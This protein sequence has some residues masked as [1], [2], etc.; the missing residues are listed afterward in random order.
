[1]NYTVKCETCNYVFVRRKKYKKCF[2][3]LEGVR[4]LCGKN[5]ETPE[6]KAKIRQWCVIRLI[7]HLDK[8]ATDRDELT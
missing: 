5:S 4:E 8:E 7:F 6:M 3:A 1:M 2:K